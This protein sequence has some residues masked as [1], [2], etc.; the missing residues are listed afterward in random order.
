MK[1]LAVISQKGGA[2]KTTLALHLAVAWSLAGRNIA[3]LDLDPQA[4][5]VKWFHRRTA[6]LPVVLPSPASLLDHEMKRIG[7]MG[8]ELL[9]LDTA[10]R[11]DSAALKA[12]KVSD[13]VVVPCRPAILDLE[14]VATTLE[15][16]R[17]TG[18]PV[19]AVL[20][21]TDVRGAEADEA[22]AAVE[23]L[24]VAVCPARLARR[25][26][27]ARS[28]VTGLAAQETEPEGKAARELEQV[29]N[30]ICEQMND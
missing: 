6:E 11:L 23:A 28:L 12:A 29:H 8:G 14:A 4:S 16:V 20:N 18:K 22:A 15:L 3:V 17:T 26:V 27:F 5:A 24:G 1:T 2:G 25:V 10:P 21:S 7:Q 30:F 19:I 9:V 13:L